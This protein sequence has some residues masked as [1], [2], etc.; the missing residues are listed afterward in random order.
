MATTAPPP[1]VTVEDIV[2]FDNSHRAYIAYIKGEWGQYLR[3]YQN[4]YI[5]LIPHGFTKN[6]LLTIPNLVPYVF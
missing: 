4:T 6:K 1:L 3:S 5:L 2:L